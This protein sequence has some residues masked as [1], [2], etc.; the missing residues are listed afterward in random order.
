NYTLWDKLQLTVDDNS[1]SKKEKLIKMNKLVASII[2]TSQGI[3]LIHAGEEIL[4]TKVNEDGSLVE[5][6]Y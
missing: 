3:S 2:L 6:S 1:L 5:N 4:R